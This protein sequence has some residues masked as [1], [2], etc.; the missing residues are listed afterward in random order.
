LLLIYTQILFKTLLKENKMKKINPLKKFT[1]L[2]LISA[3]L[4]PSLAIPSQ[5]KAD[6]GYAMTQK[7]TRIPSFQENINEKSDYCIILEII[8]NV[9]D[10]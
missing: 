8:Y 2:A 6:S 10:C 7:Q 9:S 3:G 5:V 1:F 4:I